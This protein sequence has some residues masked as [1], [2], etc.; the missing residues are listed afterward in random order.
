MLI[1][2]PLPSVPVAVKVY[3]ESAIAGT[4][5]AKTSAVTSAMKTKMFLKELPDKAPMIFPLSE[6]RGALLV[7]RKTK[8][9]VKYT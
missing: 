2:W 5:P 7:Y 1:I 3:N 4:T 6:G 9:K 8:L